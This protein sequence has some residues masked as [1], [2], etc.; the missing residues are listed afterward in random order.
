MR[1]D[2]PR[3]PIT[4]DP[5]LF[6][7][8]VELGQELIE[9]HLLRRALPAITGYPKAG[10][11]RVDKI[12]FR[13]DP[14]NPEKGRVQINAEQYFEGMPRPVWEYMIG[15]YQVANKWLKDRKGRLLT[16]DELQH[17]GRVVAAL[18][19]TI[20]LQGEIDTTIGKWPL[21]LKP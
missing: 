6:K 5:A 1:R 12:E 16:F 19:E 7:K 18:N 13:P 10:S 15:G 21:R 2:F 4:S 20:R 8:L 17:Y 3:V 9:L 14:D 11:N